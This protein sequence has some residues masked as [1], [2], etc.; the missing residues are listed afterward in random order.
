LEEHYKRHA[1]VQ[2]IVDRIKKRARTMEHPVTG[3]RLYEDMTYESKSKERNT[4]QE[5]H[6]TTMNEQAVAASG[7]QQPAA[8]EDQEPHHVCSRGEAMV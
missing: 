1:D 6:V 2:D 3:I 7:G 4:I 8:S 5:R